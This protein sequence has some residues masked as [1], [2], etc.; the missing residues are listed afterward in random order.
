MKSG[1]E[2][3]EEQTVTRERYSPHES[4]MISI[5]FLQKPRFNGRILDKNAVF[6][7]P[8]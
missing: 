6:P 3:Q 7:T 4:Y 1:G 2:Q 8:L 5:R